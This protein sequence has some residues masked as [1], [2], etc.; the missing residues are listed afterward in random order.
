MRS[1]EEGYHAGA[2]G[3]LPGVGNVLVLAE[4]IVHDRLRGSF[5]VQLEI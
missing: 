5:P 3:A 1:V 4:V 2:D